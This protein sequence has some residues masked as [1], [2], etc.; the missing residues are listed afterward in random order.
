MQKYSHIAESYAY[1]LWIFVFILLFPVNVLIPLGIC[2]TPKLSK[3]IILLP[4][5]GNPDFSNCPKSLPRNTPDSLIL[6]NWIFD[7]FTL[8]DEPFAKL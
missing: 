1:I 4:F 3:Y 2:S 8:A 6:C 7:N 5:K